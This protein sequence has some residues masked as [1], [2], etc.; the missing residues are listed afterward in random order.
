M[1]IV[2]CKTNEKPVQ[3]V[4]VTVGGIPRSVIDSVLLWKSNKLN[5]NELNMFTPLSDVKKIYKLENGR[6]INNISNKVVNKV[7]IVFRNTLIDHQDVAMLGGR[8]NG[9]YYH[10]KGRQ[11]DW[12]T[13]PY[14]LGSIEGTVSIGNYTSKFEN[15]TGYWKDFY[16]Q[17]LNTYKNIQLIIREEG[18]LTTNYKTGIWK[19]YDEKGI[20]MEEKNY[21]I[22]DSI[23][24]RFP[25]CIFNKNEPCY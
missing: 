9:T 21:M 16:F 8:P 20:L 2:G 12:K 25:H 5:V 19:Y 23:D 24:I 15:G 13:M 10:A 3:P 18:N 14:N 4:L 17:D 6:L 1:I 7:T 11:K 22:S